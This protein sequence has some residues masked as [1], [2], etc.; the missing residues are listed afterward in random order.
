MQSTKARPLQAQQST[1]LP[2]FLPLAAGIV[3]RHVRAVKHL[4]QADVATRAHMNVS[5]ISNVENGQNNIS[6]IKFSLICH[7]L[8]VQPDFVL[9]LA[10][11]L[12]LPLDT[13]IRYR[14]LREAQRLIQNR[15]PK[16][17]DVEDIVSS[18]FRL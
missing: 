10:L 3:L 5:Y 9:G 11:K 15:M 17:L 14:S 4:T 7:G 8:C 16:L 2:L 18:G 1:D 12:M 13:A 6:M